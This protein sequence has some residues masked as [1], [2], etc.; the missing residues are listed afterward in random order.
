[1]NRRCFQGKKGH[2]NTRRD[3][4]W[5]VNRQ[6][7]TVT[8]TLASPSP[9][10][11][12]DITVEHKPAC[13]GQ[14]FVYRACK[15]YIDY[16][17]NFRFI[18]TILTPAIESVLG[19]AAALKYISTVGLEEIRKHDQELVS[20]AQY[21]LKQNSHIEVLAQHSS[22]DLCAS[23]TMIIPGYESH[24]IA[25]ELSNRYN[26]FTRSGFHCAQP[27]HEYLGIPEP[28]RAS[29]YFYN[30]ISEIELLDKALRD[31]TE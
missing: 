6:R 13:S 5:M 14:D 26:I 19:W 27:L 23:V 3:K 29:F 15:L 10:F 22:R 4:P 24:R 20:L 9:A 30:D 31:I 25:Q 12:W 17:L 8:L 11:S 1:M 7:K 21:L 2:K 18:L 28:L 16:F